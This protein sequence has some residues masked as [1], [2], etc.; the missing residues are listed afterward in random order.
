MLA[1]RVFHNDMS[2]KAGNILSTIMAYLSLFA[3]IATSICW[4]SILL[5]AFFGAAF[6]LLNLSFYRFIF[7]ERGA[8]F[9]FRAVPMHYFSYLYSGIGLGIGIARYLA[10]SVI[11]RPVIEGVST[12]LRV[13]ADTKCLAAGESPG[14]Y[15]DS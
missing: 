15:P 2:T 6:L 10:S 5:F 12:E 7:S 3:L 14:E 13:E 9:T 1:E 11:K 8:F 4:Y